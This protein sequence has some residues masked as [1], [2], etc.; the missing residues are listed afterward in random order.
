MRLYVCPCYAKFAIKGIVLKNLADEAWE[1]DATPG[2]SERAQADLK[3]TR[4]LYDGI[5]H[6]F[7]SPACY[8]FSAVTLA[9]TG[10]L[11]DQDG[12]TSEP[13]DVWD[14]SFE[15]RI[16]ALGFTQ[17]KPPEKELKIKPAS[18]RGRQSIQEAIWLPR[19]GYISE[20]EMPLEEYYALVYGLPWGQ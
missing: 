1:A 4:E 9:A 10:R 16:A 13:F 3:A 6:R 8:S 17:V 15:A 19:P 14:A 2:I 18:S 20:A 11:A 12:D 7:L 5:Q